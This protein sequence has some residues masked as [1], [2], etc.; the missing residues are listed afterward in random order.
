MRFQF[1]IIGLVMAGAMLGGCG[2]QEKA[3]KP[4]PVPVKAV[5]VE[6][7]AYTTSAHITGEVAAR[8]A[9][10]LSF[11]VSGRI[12]E[13]FVNVGDHVTKGQLLAK[14][15]ARE[16]RADVDVASAN[17]QAAE[18]QLK[19]ASRSLDRQKALISN[20]VTTQAQY[21]QA[22]EA[23]RTASGTLVSSKAALATAQ[24]ALLHTELRADADGV[25]TSRDA[26]VGQ[27]A[28]AAQKIFELAHDGPRDAVF[29]VFEAL[30]LNN[31]PDSKIAVTL[32]SDPSRKAIA[33]IREISPTIDSTTGT[34]RVKVGLGDQSGDMPLGAAVSGAFEYKP[35]NVILLPW[36]AMASL[37]GQPAVW[38]IDPA[39][40][41][42]SLRKVVVSDYQTGQ[43][44]VS[45]GLQPKDLVVS[46]GGKLLTPGQAV[47]ILGKDP[48]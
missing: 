29:A 16:Q 9:S 20:Q 10:E 45:Q 40:H 25:I 26:E 37:D 17:V 41:T 13:R 14:I 28:Q 24:D 7:G 11:Q 38:L 12:V 36:G 6:L 35:R 8:V 15:D 31:E 43:F 5:K 39:A 44:S 1:R 34:I 46:E 4:A 33:E 2:P 22:D 42:V 27:V 48:Q 30:F 18:A 23:Y 47:A 19:Q 3:E 21:D 32:L